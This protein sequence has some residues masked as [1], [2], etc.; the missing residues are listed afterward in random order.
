MWDIGGRPTLPRKTQHSLPTKMNIKLNM[1]PWG[2]VTTGHNFPDQRF[3]DAGR[4]R[5]VSCHADE[6]RFMWQSGNVETFE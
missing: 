1:D 2:P 3:P 6:T 5:N 4:N